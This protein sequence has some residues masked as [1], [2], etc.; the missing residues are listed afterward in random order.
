MKRTF[1]MTA[2]LAACTILA[3]KAQTQGTVHEPVRFEDGTP[4]AGDPVADSL[5]AQ[6]R[7]LT[8]TT[9]TEKGDTLFTIRHASAYVRL[10][11]EGL[12]ADAGID[13]ILLVP[14]QGAPETVPVTV[15]EAGD[16]TLWMAKE[17]AVLPATA[18]IAQAADGRIW[19]ARLA[20]A[21][22]QPGIAHRWDA[23]C[24]TSEAP[25]SGIQAT[26][27][28]QTTMLEVEPGEYSGIT[29]I[30][31][32]Q[33]GVVSDNLKGA[34]IA[35][36]SIPIDKHGNVGTV[37]MEVPAAV[38]TAEG[39]KRDTEGI[40]YVA[41]TNTLYTTSEKNQDIRGYD[42]LGVE[43]GAKLDVPADLKA[44]QDNRG[45]ESLS[46]NASTGLFW[47]TTEA[48][49]KADTFFPRLHRLQSFTT[50]GKPAGR[51]LYQI[52]EP[53]QTSENTVA[54]VFGIPALTA[55]DDGRVLVVERE[56]YV[57][58]GSL[59]E[60]IQGAFT[61]INIYVVDPVHDTAGILRKSLVCHFTTG[62]MNLA[63]FEGMCLGPTLPDGRRCLVM[64]ADSQKGSGG[65]TQE[66]VKVILLRD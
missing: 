15:S 54:Y 24:L 18:A 40:A 66:Y 64:I 51:F 57:P 38:A 35:R 22:L 19:S 4:V 16:L 32:N 25:E 58:K 11:L 21:T 9:L 53:S 60:K 42:L 13:K 65:L 50:D 28:P 14:I 8:D 59:W 56:V 36:F 47:T 49:L 41:S 33:Y 44:I 43:T 27:L 48:R 37:K 2:G 45:F 34:G 23:T 29:W 17:P 63:N 39:K 20:G 12:P 26:P 10:Q 31:G 30:G 7:F 52:G 3:C 6:D 61:D 55:L 1:F 62:A 5:F 46:Y